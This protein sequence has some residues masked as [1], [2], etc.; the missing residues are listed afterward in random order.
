MAPLSQPPPTSSPMSPPL[1]PGLSLVVPP[2]LSNIHKI[3]AV[4]PLTTQ[5]SYAIF[6]SHEGG[7]SIYIPSR[8]PPRCLSVKS[9]RTATRMSVIEVLV[10]PWLPDG[11]GDNVSIRPVRA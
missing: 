5:Y 6:S 9:I 7:A 10:C 3:P 11:T 8:A 1:G 2:T 4:S